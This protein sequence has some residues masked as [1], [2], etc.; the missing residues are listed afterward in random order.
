[1]GT[2][3]MLHMKACKGRNKAR[4]LK[5]ALEYIYNPK[6]T[7][8]VSEKWM[9]GNCGQNAKEIYENMIR[10]KKICGKEEG[11]QGYHYILTFAKGE[12]DEELAHRVTQEFCDAFFKNEYQYTFVLHNDK[13]HLHSHI[14]FNSLDMNGNKYHYADGDWAEKIQPLVNSICKKYGLTE[15]SLKKDGEKEKEKN[16]TK[17]FQKSVGKTK[18]KDMKWRAER[19][20]FYS[21]VKSD[22]RSAI[23]VADTIEEFY[24]GMKEKNYKIREGKSKKY[25]TYITFTPEGRRGVRSYTLGKEYEYEDIKYQIENKR[26]LR[27]VDKFFITEY[28][29]VQKYKRIYFHTTPTLRKLYA[30]N[31]YLIRNWNGERLKQYPQFLKYRKSL[32][33]LKAVEEEYHYLSET[34]VSDVGEIDEKLNYLN[35]KL[36]DLGTERNELIGKMETAGEEKIEKYEEELAEITKQFKRLMKEKNILKR[37][38]GRSEKMNQE[39]KQIQREEEKKTEKR[40]RYID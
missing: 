34:G 1:M 19:K 25:G 11:R 4:H 14:I 35:Y 2:L 32:N 18:K 6:D 10:W 33:E 15:I 12:L 39:E 23:E 31:V 29:D 36:S 38:K 7:N 3:K 5:N 37:I 28:P 13:E 21:Q 9:G 24:R 30:K 8:R 17:E 20:N 16:V 22:V 26:E 40:R 27:A